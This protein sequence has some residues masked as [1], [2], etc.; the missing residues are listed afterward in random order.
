MLGGQRLTSSF[1]PKP[2]LFDSKCWRKASYAICNTH[3][4]NDF[5][6]IKKSF[7][8]LIGGLVPAAHLQTKLKAKVTMM[9]FRA[10]ISFSVLPTTSLLFCSSKNCEAMVFSPF[11]SVHG[12]AA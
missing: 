10:W 7:E 6:P 4:H 2:P 3:W 11:S 5:F 12:S 8:C 9:L 1:L